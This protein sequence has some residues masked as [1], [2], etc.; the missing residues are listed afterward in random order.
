MS[1]VWNG[2]E[3]DL[4]SVGYEMILLGRVKRNDVVVVGYR[5]DLVW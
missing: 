1:L 2:Y 3:N 4:V 5:N